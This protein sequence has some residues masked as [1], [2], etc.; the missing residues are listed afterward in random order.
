MK[1]MNSTF[2]SLQKGK[3]E[4]HGD[5]FSHVRSEAMYLHHAH[6]SNS[7]SH[8]TDREY[9]S[10]LGQCWLENM[11]H[12][13]SSLLM[14]FVGQRFGK[15]TWSSQ[16]YQCRRCS[17]YVCTAEGALSNPLFGGHQIIEL[18]QK[19]YIPS[20]EL[21]YPPTKAL[22]KMIFLSPRWDMLVPWRVTVSTQ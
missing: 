16:K 1:V 5:G 22:L 8:S 12:F 17:L 9:R 11:P 3:S 4:W 10:L 7:L 6:V 21:T 14:F 13:Q 18:W 20:W 2:G 15:Q 19:F